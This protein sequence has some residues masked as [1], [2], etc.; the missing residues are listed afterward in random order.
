MTLRKNNVVE[1]KINGQ[2]ALSAD[3]K[4]FIDYLSDS[5][6][7][8]NNKAMTKRNIYLQTLNVVYKLGLV[9]VIVIYFP[10]FLSIF[11]K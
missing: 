11:I 3:A 9:T 5:I 4:Q 7:Q 2:T 6:V 8:K 1:I 10:E